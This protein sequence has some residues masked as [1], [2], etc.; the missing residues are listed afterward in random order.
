MLVD[1]Y[2][3]LLSI[4]QVDFSR[5]SLQIE[6]EQNTLWQWYSLFPK[7]FFLISLS[8]ESAGIGGQGYIYC[9]LMVQVFLVL[10]LK[11]TLWNI[12]GLVS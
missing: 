5:I 10:I 3:P 4:V 12:I 6:E 11:F 2:L 7:D 9:N 1:N 8:K